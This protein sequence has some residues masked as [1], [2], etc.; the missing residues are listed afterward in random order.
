MKHQAQKIPMKM[1]QETQKKVKHL[2][3]PTLSQKYYQMIKLQ[4]V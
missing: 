2:Q 1:N 3:L 4:K